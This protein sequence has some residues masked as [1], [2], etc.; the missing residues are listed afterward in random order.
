MKEIFGVE[1]GIIGF[2]ILNTAQGIGIPLTIGIRNPSSTEKDSGIHGVE[3]IVQVC[4]GSPLHGAKRVV[5][6]KVS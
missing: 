6:T 4:L 2:R 3:S 5:P 1:S